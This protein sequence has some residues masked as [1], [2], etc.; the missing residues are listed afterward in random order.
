VRH[1]LLAPALCVF[2]GVLLG[3]H[4]AYAAA[5]YRN[6]YPMAYIEYYEVGAVLYGLALIESWW[7]TTRG[8]V[9]WKGRKYP[10]AKTP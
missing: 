4:V 6:L 9:V 3:R 1:S 2:V 10:A 8:H 5:L 7:K